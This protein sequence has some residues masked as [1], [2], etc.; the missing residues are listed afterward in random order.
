MNK[1]RLWIY[2]EK[3]NVGAT[4]KHIYSATVVS[5]IKAW[6]FIRKFNFFFK[7]VIY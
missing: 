6:A 1:P 2:M 5:L 7:L 3:K 4:L